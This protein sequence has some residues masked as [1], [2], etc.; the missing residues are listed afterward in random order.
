MSLQYLANFLAG[1]ALT[2]ET[3]STTSEMMELNK[4]H[5]VSLM[6]P[7]LSFSILTPT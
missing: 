2:M 6:M 1:T 5:W 7:F 4:A 3:F